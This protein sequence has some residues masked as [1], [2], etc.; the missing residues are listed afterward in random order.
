MD[1][2]AH[3]L[4]AFALFK[5]YSWQGEGVFFGILPDLVFGIPALYYVLTTP[6]GK[7]RDSQYGNIFPKIEPV[8]R[9]AHSAVTMLLC[10]AIASVFLRAPYWPL[11][12][13]WSLHILLDL[14]MHK[15]GW[16]QGLAPLYPF[17]KR[18]LNRGWWWKEVIERRPW[19]AVVNYALALLVYFIA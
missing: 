15:G 4:W 16:V 7:F 18:R 2:P 1:L 8:Y 14:P 11:L 17:S 13:G 5:R 12:A 10:F 9:F 3:A 19:I 6:G